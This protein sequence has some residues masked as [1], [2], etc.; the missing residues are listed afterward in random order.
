VPSPFHQYVIILAMSL[1]IRNGP[2]VFMNVSVRVH[3]AALNNKILNVNK[4]TILTPLSF[5]FYPTIWPHVGPK[6]VD[7]TLCIY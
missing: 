6:N 7:F 2:G 3:R 1:N 5:L 4:F